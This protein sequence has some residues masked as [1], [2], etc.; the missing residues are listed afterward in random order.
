LRSK[1]LTKRAAKLGATPLVSIWISAPYDRQARGRPVGRLR[2]ASATGLTRGT[3]INSASAVGRE[4]QPLP[5]P[6]SM[7][8]FAD[9]DRP[10]PRGLRSLDSLKSGARR[11]LA[12]RAKFERSH[13]LPHHMFL[14]SSHLCERFRTANRAGTRRLV[15]EDVSHALR[16]RQCY[17]SVIHRTYMRSL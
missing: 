10:C 5:T 6:A 12:M 4:L 9:A 3:S 16:N 2:A 15:L 13:C 8:A 17:I 7:S 1:L 11:G 14:S